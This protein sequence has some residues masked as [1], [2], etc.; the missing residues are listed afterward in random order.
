MPVTPVS[1]PKFKFVQVGQRV[2]IEADSWLLALGKDPADSP[3]QSKNITIDRAIELSDGLISRTTLWRM[4]RAAEA[5]TNA[6]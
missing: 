5:E 3:D 4:R 1:Y 6:A 2:F